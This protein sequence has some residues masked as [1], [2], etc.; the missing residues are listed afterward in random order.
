MATI[1]VTTRPAVPV[2]RR[3]LRAAQRKQIA[4]RRAALAATVV[5]ASALSAA[6]TAAV[7]R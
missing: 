1:T 2:T 3:D 6:V 7:R 4:V 5:G